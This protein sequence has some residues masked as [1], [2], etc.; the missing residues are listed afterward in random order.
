MPVDLSSV[1]I[2]EDGETALFRL[3]G[4][5]ATGSSGTFD[6]ENTASFDGSNGLI[7]HGTVSPYIIVD[8]YNTGDWGT[9]NPTVT[10]PLGDETGG[11]AGQ[12]ITAVYAAYGDTDVYFRIDTVETPAQNLMHI[13]IDN[14]AEN[15]PDRY[16]FGGP[17]VYDLDIYLV[18]KGVWLQPELYLC[19]E[20][21]WTGGPSTG[22]VAVGDIVEVSIPRSDFGDVDNMSFYVKYGD[23]SDFAPNAG[24]DPATLIDLSS[25]SATVAESG[26]LVAWET[27]S[28]VDNAG[29]NLYRADSANG[30]YVKLNDGLISAQGGPTQGASYSFLDAGSDGGHY[31]LE[32]VDTGGVSTFHGPISAEGGGPA[33][34]GLLSFAAGALTS[35][36]PSLWLLPMLVL[37]AGSLVLLR[38]RR[39][40]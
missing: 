11:N 6:I 37:G 8:G 9:I 38:H 33:A 14:G 16:G 35:N 24:S 40:L 29:F 3:Y 26:V 10:D 5:G 34:V 12:D 22:T 19:S 23:T 18:Y 7:V 25:F 4:W 39:R 13:V 31:K 28:E 15:C 20:N 21:A 1:P 17:A 2:V 30:E 36:V 27:A 32:D